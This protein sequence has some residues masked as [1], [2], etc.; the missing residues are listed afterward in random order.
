MKPLKYKI[1]KIDQE[2]FFLKLG[3][4]IIVDLIAEKVY[5]EDG[6][7]FAPLDLIEKMGVDG[8]LIKEGE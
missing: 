2:C 8:E 5:S 6:K 4:V 3:A 1:T 7:S